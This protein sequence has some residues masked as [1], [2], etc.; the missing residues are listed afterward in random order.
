[1]HKETIQRVPNAMAGRDNPE[2]VVH[3]ME[4]VPNDLIHEKR[5]KL[6]EE[7]GLSQIDKR[8]KLNAYTQMLMNMAQGHPQFQAFQASFQQPPVMR[9][10]N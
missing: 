2:I 7:Q 5:Q 6:L 4:G 8:H 3:G 9:R 1:M 10:F